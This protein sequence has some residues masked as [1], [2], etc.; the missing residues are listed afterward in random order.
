ME[1]YVLLWDGRVIHT[2]INC[3]VPLVFRLT[4]QPWAH[5]I[6]QQRCTWGYSSA[7]KLSGGNILQYC[8]QQMFPITALIQHLEFERISH[9]HLEGMWV[10]EKGWGCEKEQGGRMGLRS[11]VQSTWEEFPGSC[12]SK[13]LA[14]MHNWC[15]WMGSACLIAKLASHGQDWLPALCCPSCK[16]HLGILKHCLT[17]ALALCRPLAPLTSSWEIHLEKIIEKNPICLSKACLQIKWAAFCVGQMP[18]CSWAAFYFYIGVRD[19][20]GREVPKEKQHLWTD[21][22]K[23]PVAWQEQSCC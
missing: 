8:R 1:K 20:E 14:D 15:M 22:C 3:A 10:T 23:L 4:E 12:W 5:P 19:G 16:F 9:F 13:R 18:S 17:L 21:K 7:D 6:C 11:P 2:E